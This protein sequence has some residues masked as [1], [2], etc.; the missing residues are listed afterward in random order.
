MVG[1]GLSLSV[2]LFL[3]CCVQRSNCSLEDVLNSNRFRRDTENVDSSVVPLLMQRIWDYHQYYDTKK[4]ENATP[5][6]WIELAEDKKHQ[7]LSGSRS[8]FD[9]IHVDFEFEFYGHTVRRV[10]LSTSGILSMSAIEGDGDV[11]HYI[12]PF[13]GSFNPSYKNESAIY[14]ESVADSLVVEWRNVYL[15]NRTDLGPFTFQT[16]VEKDG[17]VAFI[18]KKVPIQ[19]NLSVEN[20]E[21]LIGIVGSI[22]IEVAGIK[23]L[24]YY[25]PVQVFPLDI[26][27]GTVVIF[28]PLPTC[29]RQKDME[30]CLWSALDFECRWCNATQKCY[31][32]LD[33]YTKEWEWSGCLKEET[34]NRKP[35]P[36]NPPQTKK[37]KAPESSSHVGIIVIVVIV[38]VLIAALA[39][40]CLYAYKN[41][42][43]SSGL[44][45]MEHRPSQ[46]KS[47]FMKWRGFSRQ[48]E[49]QT[50]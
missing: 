6:H 43:T 5:R 23:I 1:F 21:F 11:T 49:E 44:W 32:G 36:T 19:K 9:E 29:D 3:F 31:D 27:D 12:A 20:N 18:Y 26:N 4:T 37:P 50:A 48:N 24:A 2:F 16:K 41:P 47:L 42:N 14:Y 38:V 22:H 33:R 34:A 10:F 17:T 28:N 35:R 45:L 30:S 7:R 25:D 40:W 46:W 13:Y 8:S 39:G 15:M